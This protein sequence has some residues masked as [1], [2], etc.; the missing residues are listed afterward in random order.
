M[1]V[2]PQL[3][4]AEQDLCPRNIDEIANERTPLQHNI[5]RLFSSLAKLRTREHSKELFLQVGSETEVAAG[6]LEHTEL[7][8]LDEEQVR[9]PWYVSLVWATLIILQILALVLL[10]RL[11]FYEHESRQNLRDADFS[12]RTVPI[13]GL[14]KHLLQRESYWAAEQVLEICFQRRA[15]LY[16]R[17]MDIWEAV[18]W[19]VRSD[20]FDSKNEKLL[21]KIAI[22]Q[23]VC[24]GALRWNLSNMDIEPR[25]SRMWSWS[26][27]RSA[28]TQFVAQQD[29]I[30]GAREW[31]VSHGSIRAQLINID[32]EIIHS[33]DEEKR[34]ESER[35][36]FAVN[37]V[38]RSSKYLGVLEDLRTRAEY[39][40]DLRLIPEIEW[41]IECLSGSLR[42]PIQ[43]LHDAHTG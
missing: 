1:P 21:A 9:S 27:A 15:L 40:Q 2:F 30:A 5:I 35:K 13:H 29:G 43:T 39:N 10:F 6:L 37:D 18:E 31:K 7:A 34:G 8:D 12:H 33:D 41:R 24:E 23:T 32:R 11:R 26:I 20:E 28:L 19:F 4:A 42:S 38:E 14:L 36:A 17:F 16:F 3:S 22:M 25:G